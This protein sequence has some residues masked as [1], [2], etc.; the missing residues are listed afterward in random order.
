[1][2]LAL[3][4]IYG[5]TAYAVQQREREVAIRMAL[6]AT[7]DSITRMFLKDGG[8]V[9]AV[10]LT[11]GLLGAIPVA[12]MLEH[13]IHGVKPLDLATFVATSGLMMLTGLLATWWPARRA[14]AQSPSRLLNE[15]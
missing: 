10:G 11:C 8:V 5:I 2:F 4:G 3:L 6:G 9:L 7:G 14:A 12:R 15:I 1:M 13:Q